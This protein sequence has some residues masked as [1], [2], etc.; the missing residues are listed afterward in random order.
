MT[1][2]FCQN[3]KDPIFVMKSS[4][5]QF[6]KK[7]NTEICN[8][9]FVFIFVNSITGSKILVFATLS[10]RTNEKFRKSTCSITAN[11]GHNKLRKLLSVWLWFINEWKNSI[12]FKFDNSFVLSLDK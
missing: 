8:Q 2:L 5:F 9:K 4:F 11:P 7:I 3:Q 6:R 12:F 10:F 1:L